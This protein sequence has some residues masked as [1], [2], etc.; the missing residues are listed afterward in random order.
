MKNK[1]LTAL[2][3]CC[4]MLLSAALAGCGEKPQSSS[5]VQ[6]SSASVSAPASSQPVDDSQPAQETPEKPDI[7]Q[8]KAEQQQIEQEI[9]DEVEGSAYTPEEPL[10]VND[11]YGMSPLTAVI[12]FVTTEPS[13]VDIEVEGKDEFTTVKHSFEEPATVHILPVHG[14]Y[15]AQSNKVNLKITTEAGAETQSTVTIDTDPLPEDIAL[16]TVKTS[17]PEKM[18]AGFTLFSQAGM[19]LNYPLAIDSNGDIRWYLSDKSLGGAMTTVVLKNGNIIIGSGKAVPDSIFS[20]ISMYEMSMLGKYVFEYEVFGVHHDVKEKE[21]GNLLAAAITEGGDTINDIIVE[22][23]R[24][25]GEIINT[26]DLRKII[27]L[28]KYVSKKDYGDDENNWLH[29]N[30]MWYLEEEN[31]LVIS[32]RVQ[33]LVAKIN[34]NDNSLVWALTS[35]VAGDGKLMEPYILKSEGENFKYPVAQHA[36]VVMPDGRIILFD[37]CYDLD[38]VEKEGEKALRSRVSI[39]S[40][41]EKNMTVKQDWSYGGDRPEIYSSYVGDVQY[42]GENHYM[43]DFGGTFKKSDGSFLDIRTSETEDL[44]NSDVSPISTLIEVLNDEVVFEAVLEGGGY[45]NTYKAKRYEP[46]SGAANPAF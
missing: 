29:N 11:P 30:G 33:D 32:G 4:V 15:S 44:Y 6:S 43:M 39:Y 14:L 36:P 27:P 46:F 5:A 40:V 2:L 41:D 22:I 10:V 17:M 3:T 25:T 23:D 8:L 37:N 13:R 1:R 28:E 45:A 16:A 21:N 38:T 18:Q 34:L 12:G 7:S 35:G 19:N 9:R 42:L 20:Q 26:I 24:K 31:A